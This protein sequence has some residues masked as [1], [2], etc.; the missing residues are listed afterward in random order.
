MQF[1]F[2]GDVPSWV[3]LA[4]ALAYIGWAVIV[5]AAGYR[6]RNKRGR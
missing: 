5:G 2:D 4:V 1:L 6:G 3:C